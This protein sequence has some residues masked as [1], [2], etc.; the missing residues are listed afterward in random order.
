MIW[1][2]KRLEGVDIVVTG[3]GATDWQ[4]VFGKVMQGVGMHCKAHNIPAVAI[5][6]SMGKGAEDIFDYGIE[7]MITTING[8][9]TLPEALENAEELYLCAA[10]RMFRMLRAGSRLA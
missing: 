2:I 5:V 1:L 10:R 9:M 8:V 3:E 6:G 7:S 4:S